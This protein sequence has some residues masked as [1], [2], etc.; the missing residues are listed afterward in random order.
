MANKNSTSSQPT[1]QQSGQT[2]P[3]QQT[4]PA[5]QPTARPSVNTSPR[6]EVRNSQH[7]KIT[8]KTKG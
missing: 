7:E 5:S 6:M 4:P 2:Q 3:T 8:Y 1:G